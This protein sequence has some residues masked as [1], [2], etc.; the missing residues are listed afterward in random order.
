MFG[1]DFDLL[2]FI[3]VGVEFV[4]VNVGGGIKVFLNVV[5]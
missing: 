1:G 4:V 2:C 3:G 5:R